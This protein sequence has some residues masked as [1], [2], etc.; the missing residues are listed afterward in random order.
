MITHIVSTYSAKLT[1]NTEPK[2]N[3]IVLDSMRT[4]LKAVTQKSLEDFVTEH[5]YVIERVKE[6]ANAKLL[7]RQ[8]VILLLY[9]LV[10][11]SPAQVTQYWPFLSEELD[12]IF[13]DLGISR[14]T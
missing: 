11:T 5:D 1:F 3:A 8:P 6:R 9:L 14:S 10:A 4:M 13:S 7:Y 2:L 12:P